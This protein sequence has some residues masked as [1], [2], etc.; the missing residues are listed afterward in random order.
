MHPD[1]LSQR[2]TELSPPRK[3]NDDFDGI[4]RWIREGCRC[5][6]MPDLASM[7]IVELKPSMFNRGRVVEGEALSV[8]GRDGSI[9]AATIRINKSQWIRFSTAEKRSL[10]MHEVCHIVANYRCFPKDADHNQI[11]VEMMR[12]CGE[13]KTALYYKSGIFS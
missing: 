9:K 8:F 12:R 3:S 5:C 11:W 4:H 10:I 13:G 2:K 7:I 1:I 6:G